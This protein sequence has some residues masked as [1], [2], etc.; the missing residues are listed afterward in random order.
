[1]TNAL[2]ISLITSAIRAKAPVVGISIPDR[3]PIRIKRSQL[4][5]T[6]KGLTVLSARYECESKPSLVIRASG[7]GCI[8]AF[9]RIY[10]LDKAVASKLI[11]KWVK[12]ERVKLSKPVLTG[13]A[14]KIAVLKEKL[15]K[16]SPRPTNPCL[17]NT[18]P[19]WVRDVSEYERERYMQWRHEKLWRKQYRS[20]EA[21]QSA[22]WELYTLSGG[23]IRKLTSRPFGFHERSN[24]QWESIALRARMYMWPENKTQRAHIRSMIDVLA[25]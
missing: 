23:D 11:D 18:R 14:K 8:S 9:R 25:A 5:D 6:L 22:A 4:R 16:A 2:P 13:K 7:K 19:S 15:A 20:E 24:S 12:S 10:S 17:G 21:M 1:M 3:A